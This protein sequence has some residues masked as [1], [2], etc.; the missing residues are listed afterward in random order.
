[1]HE[2]GIAE[3][4]VR[5]VT[6]EL[7]RVAPGARLLRVRVVAGGLRQIVPENLTFAYEVLT[8]ETPAAGSV[9]ELV[10]LPLIGACTACGRRGELHDA[11]FLCEA[12]GGA[13]RP[14]GGMELY[15]DALEIDTDDAG[16]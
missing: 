7:A 8:R 15:L 11:V 9:L 13:V 3:E 16:D 1:M 12:C 2:F 10:T 14:D 4:L 5:G 6:A